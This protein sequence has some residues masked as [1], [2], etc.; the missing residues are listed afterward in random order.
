MTSLP[1]VTEPRADR[2]RSADGTVIAF[3]RI[4]AGPPLIIVDP[5]LCDR[6]MGQSRKL[7]TLLAPQFSVFIYD[8][9]GRGQSGNTPP[10]SPEREVEDVAALLDVTGGSA[11]LWGMSSGAVLALDAAHALPEIQKVMVYEPPLIVDASRPAMDEQWRIIDTAIAADRPGDAIKTFLRATGVPAPALFVLRMT[12]M[13]RKLERL[14]PTLRNDGM[15]LGDL[16]RGLP[17]PRDRW[18]NV[19]VPVLVT[20]GGRS[21]AWIRRGNEALARV[22]P[23][24]T[25]RTIPRQTHRL[26]AKVHAPILATFFSA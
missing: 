8:R 15:V 26:I 3:E 25:Y 24:A 4:G 17:L 23:N 13:W 22:L 7:A 20:D 19:R 9:R 1:K 2:V 10:Y 6:D 18:E 21:P 5:A 14:A 11:A 16:Q 12:P